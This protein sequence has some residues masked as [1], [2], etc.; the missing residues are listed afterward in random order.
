MPRVSVII[1]SYN[2]AQFLAKRLTSIFDQTYSDYEIIFLDDHSTDNSV[3]I[4]KSLKNEKCVMEIY[5]S[6]NSGSLYKQWNRG[7]IEAKGEYLWFAESDDWSDKNFLKEMVSLLDNNPKVG[8]GYCRS[9]YIDSEDNVVFDNKEWAPDVNPAF[10]ETDFVMQGR[11]FTSNYLVLNNVVNNSS[12]V[13]IRRDIWNKVGE[14]DESIKFCGDWIQWAKIAEISDI[15]FLSK[16]LNYYRYHNITVRSKY[17]TSHQEYD[18]M[19]QVYQFIVDNFTVPENISDMRLE[20]LCQEW[21]GKVIYN[22]G[23]NEIQKVNALIK[24]YLELKKYDGSLLNRVLRYLISGYK[25]KTM[26]I[27]GVN[28]QTI[29]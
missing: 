24:L 19:Y 29:L 20:R 13:L 6:E 3:D 11:D 4:F 9:N 18:E 27:L 22:S 5:N 7:V 28:E 1:P 12:S 17:L 23:F 14:V 21:V 15:A 16:R 25:E 26:R 8:M 10:W 2:H